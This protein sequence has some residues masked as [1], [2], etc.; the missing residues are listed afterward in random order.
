MTNDGRVYNETVLTFSFDATATSFDRHRALPAG[1]AQS[2]RAAIRSCSLNR[3]GRVLDLG[4]GT[5]RIGKAFVQADDFYVG[6][7]LSWAM[8][9]EFAVQC[10]D[11]CLLQAHGRCLPFA[12]R[13]FDLVLFMQVLSGAADWTGLLQEALRV[14]ASPGM[15][16]VGH[17]VAPDAGLDSQL[18]RQLDLILEETGIAAHKSKKSQKGALT[19]LQNRASSWQTVTAAKWLAQRSPRQFMARHRTAA[20]FAALPLTVQDEALEK[21]SAWAEAHFGLLEKRFTEEHS[22]ELQAF[23]IG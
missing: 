8:L 7:D 13:V 16:I 1:V 12:H 3:N 9:R 10:P 2:I 21:L 11:A 17:A 4:A 15:V 23:R 18:K 14:L 20:R 5:G 22:F 19:W 6:V